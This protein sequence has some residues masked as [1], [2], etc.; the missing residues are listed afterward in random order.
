MPSYRYRAHGIR[1]ESEFVLPGLGLSEDR[2]PADLMVRSSSEK[3]EPA[4]PEESV[5]AT[6]DVAGRGL[7][8]CFNGHR[9]R[10]EF[11]EI[12]V[13]TLADHGR[14]LTVHTNLANHAIVPWL[15]VGSP[16]ALALA[17][18]GHL[19]LHASSVRAG[20]DALV[21]CAPSGGGKS[22]MAAL[23]CAA[24]ATLISEDTSRMARVGASWNVH[25][26]SGQLRLRHSKESVSGLF[27]THR[28]SDSGDERQLVDLSGD[29][30]CFGV[31]A[32][33]IV[34]LDRSADTTTVTEIEPLA[35]LRLVL[36]SLR[37]QGLCDSVLLAQSF[38]SV[39]TLVGDV[40]TRLL[41]VPWRGILDPAL[42]THALRMLANAN[43][44]EPG[45]NGALDTQSTNAR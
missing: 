29:D 32:L 11:G 39:A 15:V 1:I 42:G 20:D 36:G 17:V 23:M 37:L 31:G 33:V 38:D 5:V 12:A 6:V 4:G 22:T 24:G 26:G 16:V 35:A 40:P 30:G 43:Q 10:L 7:R 8:V 28:V 9:Y 44:S 25:V 19:V 18:R 21:L 41:R 45:A 34:T 13:M 14:D 2:L 27:P 3:A